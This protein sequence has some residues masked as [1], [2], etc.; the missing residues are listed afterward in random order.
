M[1]NDDLTQLLNQF[2]RALFDPTA[3]LPTLWPV[4]A[5]G[6]FLV[7]VTQIGAGIPLGVIMAR[8]AGIPIPVTALLY[9]ASDVVLAIA[10]EPM[11]ILLRWMGKRVDFLGRLGARLARF[12]GMA[13]LQGGGVRGPLG[14]ILFSFTVAPAPAR[15]AS[16]AAGHGPLSGWTLAIAGDMLYFGMIMASTLWISSLFGGDDR[17]TVGAV[18]I[19]TWVVPMLIRRMRRNPAPVRVVSR[20]P[21]RVAA[22]TADAAVPGGSSGARA[23]RKAPPQTGRRRRSSRGL[24]R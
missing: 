12:S 21:L 10:M 16:E 19:G 14:L 23:A 15:A 8:N 18:L 2:S 17:L 13:G 1:S 7:F 3:P 11:L 22:V 6:V 20:T 9:L 24:H 5:M 4:G